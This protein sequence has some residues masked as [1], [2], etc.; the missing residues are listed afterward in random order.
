MT[1]AG[2][3]SGFMNF[4]RGAGAAVLVVLAAA[5]LV[6][7]GGVLLFSGDNTGKDWIDFLGI[8]LAAVG[9]AISVLF[10]GVIRRQQVR[11]SKELERTKTQFASALAYYNARL[12]QITTREFEAYSRLW[13]GLAR[14][15]RAL[16]TL[17]TG[18]LDEDAVKAAQKL[19]EDAEGH[20]L[21]V[22]ATDRRVFYDFWQRSLYIWGEAEKLKGNANGLKELW[23]REIK[24]S[25]A[26]AATGTPPSGPA[27]EGYYKELDSIR[28]VF[29]EK[30]AMKVNVTPEQIRAVLN[31]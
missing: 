15:Y 11:D 21:L 29:Y 17:Q 9:S 7:G 28:S 2:F 20:C 18:V 4:V 25:P 27:F 13:S 3:M 5:L 16:Y 26:V 14:F 24:G 23:A 12:S 19:C 8:C 6:V 1:F 22:D 30:L 31:P 10:G